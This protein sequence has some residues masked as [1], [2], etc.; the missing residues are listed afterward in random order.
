MQTT[1]AL[2]FDCFGVFYIDPVF[3]YMR[4]PQ[5]PP[6]KAAALHHLDEQAARGKL[7]KPDFV[8]QAASLLGLSAQQVEEQFFR[9]HSSNDPL[10]RYVRTLRE[11]YKIALLSNIGADMMDGFFSKQEMSELFDVVV[12]SG[13]TGYAKPDP[14]I[15]IL[16]CKRLGVNPRETI[17]IDDMQGNIDA[18]KQL[19]MKG[20]RYT[21]FEEFKSELEAITFQAN[22]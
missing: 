2:I 16:T 10:L 12:L 4:D 3:A 8:T 7:S 13:S 11:Q 17:M 20:I 1:K 6:D 9:P 14:E 22:P 19:G 18:A 5:S 15:Y 21:D